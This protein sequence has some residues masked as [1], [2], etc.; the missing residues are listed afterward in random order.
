[1]KKVI[2]LTALG[3]AYARAGMEA[4]ADILRLVTAV[5]SEADVLGWK[6]SAVARTEKPRIFTAAGGGMPAPELA[7]SNMFARGL[8]DLMGRLDF[9][10]IVRSYS[11]K[12]KEYS[13]ELETA[14]V[15]HAWDAAAVLAL[16]GL[17]LPAIKSK[18]LLFT[19]E[20]GYGGPRPGWLDSF[21]RKAL[22]DSQALVL[23]GAWDCAE[24]EAEYRHGKRSLALPRGL[25]DFKYLR[26]GSIRAELGAGTGDILVCS[27][28]RLA[29][30]KGF[31]V[32]IDAMAL[33]SE[34]TPCNI[35]C[36]IAGA[37]PE[38]AALAARLKAA[39]LE[40]RVKLLGFREDAGELL[41]DSDVFVSTALKTVSDQGLLEAM[42]AGLA[43]VASNAGGNP[44]VLGWGEAGTLVPPG[45]PEAL[46]AAITALAASP[47]E[48]VYL[49][50]KSRDYYVKHHTLRALAAAAAAVYNSIL[51]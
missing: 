3:R 35:Y 4:G 14:D 5:N 8:K 29:A 26:R 33:A 10:G 11:G 12:L 20:A 51:Q 50:A 47:R 6:A 38:A 37:G 43:I 48:L 2:Y 28:G 21:R 45:N 15:L 30:E 19:P 40:N 41:A 36:A 42:R 31:S 32:L 34:K 23:P 27:F 46:A 24:L 7:P 17:D 18:P 44:E 22:A 39:G 13:D 1:M 9:T 49:S 16:K 25:E